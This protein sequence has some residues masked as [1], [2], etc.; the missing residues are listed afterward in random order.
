MS[1]EM[2]NNAKTGT[3]IDTD[4]SAYWRAGLELGG[5]TSQ[6]VI[7]EVTGTEVDGTTITIN[8]YDTTKEH[9]FT[10]F[11]GDTYQQTYTGKNKWKPYNYSRNSGNIDWVTSNNG[12]ISANGTANANSFSAIASGITSEFYLLSAGTYILSGATTNLALQ[13]IDSDSNVI[14]TTD[15]T[16][17]ATFTLSE[18]KSIQVRGRIENGVQVSNVIVYPMIRLSSVADDS[19]E[20]YVRRTSKSKSNVSSKRSSCNRRE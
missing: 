12:S 9:K 7:A 6:E 1:S 2:E 13:V 11:S 3:S 15:N 19:Y 14:A 5:N 18:A 8:D 20:P 10:K 17:I 4:D 16:T